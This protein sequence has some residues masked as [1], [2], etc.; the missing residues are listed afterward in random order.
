MKRITDSRKIE[1]WLKKEDIRSHFD[2]PGLQF[3]ATSYEPGEFITSPQRHVE[4][5]LFLV[6]GTV[7]IYGIREDGRDYPI[8]EVSHMALLGDMEYIA[9]GRSVFFAEAKTPT[10]CLG[11][12]V[13]EYRE[14]LDQDVRFLHLLL[15]SYAKKIFYFSELEA[16]AP[17]L[18]EKLL[19]YMKN[20]C[21]NQELHGI[22]TTVLKLRTSRRQLQRVLKKLCEEGRVE[23][24]GRG[25]YRLL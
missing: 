15:H 18:E 9:Q 22:E 13:R 10:V 23:K 8:N 1:D 19:F 14:Q 4:E 16:E 5:L 25:R 20:A 12:S 2:T 17:T 7:K 3:Y 6:E 11:L 21:P 24:T